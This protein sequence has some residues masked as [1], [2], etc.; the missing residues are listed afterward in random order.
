MH[1]K[2][3]VVFA[4]VAMIPVACAVPTKRATADT[5]EWTELHRA[6]QLASAAYTGCIG[7]AFDVTITK[8][9]N[10]LVTDTQGFIGY[11][12]EKKRITVA[13]RGST[14][15]TDIANDVDT[16]LVT[17][18]LSGIN[19]PSGAQIMH[20]IYSPWSSVHDTVISEVKTLVEQYPD[21]DLESTG[22]S[23]GGSL[24]YMSYI[25]LAQ[26]FPEKTV[27]SNALAAYPIGNSA[28]AEF[29]TSQ[30]GTLNRGNNA[31]DGVPNMYIMWPYDFV[32]YGTE[33]Y[34]SGT[35]SSTVKC[36]GERD[37]QCSAGNGQLGVTAGHFSNFGIAM[38]MA[39]CSAS[40]L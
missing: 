39:G 16:T 6:A 4:G 26:N 9:L 36:S 12:T 1:L 23:L 28:F 40:L 27:I 35:Q 2:K 30:N 32:H 18:S 11:S 24:T 34:S 38:G 3:S 29:G 7:T 14:S 37:T 31:D 20:G 25:A 17:P 15:A 13:M 19:F 22:H 5:A 10:D 21:Y 33:Y 8:Q